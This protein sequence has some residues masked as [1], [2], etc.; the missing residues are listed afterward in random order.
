M[1][2]MR[3]RKLPK[4]DDVMMKLDPE[5]NARTIYLE[6]RNETL[7]K[8]EKFLNDNYYKLGVDFNKST[9]QEGQLDLIKTIK[10]ILDGKL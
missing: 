4:L 7:T 1:G 2:K 5:T 10:L 8:V 9:Y 6:Q 3:K